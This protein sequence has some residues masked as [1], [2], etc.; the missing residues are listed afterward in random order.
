M[1]LAGQVVCSVL[2]AVYF[3]CAVSCC[4]LSCVC[5]SCLLCAVCCLSSAL[6][7]VLSLVVRCAPLRATRRASSVSL[8]VCVPQYL[9][10]PGRFRLSFPKLECT[11]WFIV[12]T[13]VRTSKTPPCQIPNPPHPMTPDLDLQPRGLSTQLYLT[14]E[15][16]CL[17]PQN[18]GPQRIEFKSTVSCPRFLLPLLTIFLRIPYASLQRSAT[19][20]ARRNAAT[21]NRLRRRRPRISP[22]FNVTL[23]PHLASGLK[24]RKCGSKRDG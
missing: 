9:K 2:H 24:T 17:C 13:K 7:C 22:L 18:L 21:A 11:L 12:Y 14:Y 3:H 5:C 16:H 8:T 6:C 15:H 23:V 10:R 20:C 1:K 4:L 19:L